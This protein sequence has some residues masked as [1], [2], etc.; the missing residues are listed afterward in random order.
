MDPRLKKQDPHTPRYARPHTVQQYSISLNFVNILLPQAQ[1]AITNS[2]AVD[3][4]CDLGIESQ[5]TDCATLVF[6]SETAQT[7][8]ALY[9]SRYPQFRIATA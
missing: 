2:V 1:D 5:Q 6:D 9:M 8:A 3:L 7:M 4:Y